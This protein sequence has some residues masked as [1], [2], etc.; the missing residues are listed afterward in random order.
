[1]RKWILLAVLTLPFQ[2]AVAGR[3]LILGA[4]KVAATLTVMVTNLSTKAQTVTLKGTGAGGAV[5]GGPVRTGLVCAEKTFTFGSSAIS[6]DQT[7]TFRVCEATV[8]VAPKDIVQL[9]SIHFG[10][11]HI[12]QRSW[13]TSAP[14][15][16]DTLGVAEL[17]VHENEG[18][19]TGNLAVQINSW[20]VNTWAATS[21]VHNIPLNGGRAF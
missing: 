7:N 16:A 13:A 18:F 2:S 5:V 21:G 14:L 11:G 12:E 10:I 3:K 1:M 15:P 20:G 17:Y 8:T 6:F 9:P 4:T 19:L